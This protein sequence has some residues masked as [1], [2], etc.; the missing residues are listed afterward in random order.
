[1][2]GNSIQ[3]PQ[4]LELAMLDDIL[5]LTEIGNTSCQKEYNFGPAHNNY[6]PE[7]P[8]EAIERLD[9]LEINNYMDAD[10]TSIESSIAS[11]L[12]NETSL[13]V[14]EERIYYN[15]ERTRETIHQVLTGLVGKGGKVA[16]P[17]P[18]WY[19]WRSIEKDSFSFQ[20]FNALSEEQLVEGFANIAKKEK[21]KALL[22][23]NPANPLM[24]TMCADALREINSIALHHGIDIVVDDI[25]RGVSPIGKRES[26][27]THFSRPYVIEGFS[28]RFGDTFF[29]DMSYVLSPEGGKSFSFN[30]IDKLKY[31]RGEELKQ[32][33]DHCSVQ[34]ITELGIRNLA[35][36]KGLHQ[37]CPEAKI[38][39]PSPTHIT[40]LIELP[41]KYRDDSYVFFQSALKE[42]LIVTP[43]K[44]F[45]PG[46]D[47]SYSNFNTHLLRVAVGKMSPLDIYTGAVKLGTK[48]V[49]EMNVYS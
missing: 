23:V 36:D 14:S 10:L 46:E 48:I 15:E 19:F 25:L 27:G 34:A 39:R 31:M 41:K 3:L 4:E 20:Y 7:L 32:V 8:L 29:G 49:Q 37:T 33:Y 47:G 26:I 16:L 5:K 42:G 13:P 18:N 40:S 9:A 30:Y 43:I 2:L 12:R 24:Y 21:V 6:Q 11:I 1:M 45:Y 28:K 38:T 22:L 44:A 35:F 17:V